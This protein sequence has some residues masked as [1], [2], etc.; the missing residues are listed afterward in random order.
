MFFDCPCG[1]LHVSFFRK[2]FHAGACPFQLV[3]IGGPGAPH[4]FTFLKR[5]DEDL[6]GVEIDESRFSCQRQRGDVILRRTHQSDMHCFEA[7]PH[8][9]MSFTMHLAGQKGGSQAL[10]S[11]RQSRFCL[12]RL[13]LPRCLLECLQACET[14]NT[15]EKTVAVHQGWEF[16]QPLLHRRLVGQA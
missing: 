14:L 11:P 7:P 10:T 1:F 16:F 2:G 12:E 4:M 9:V 8:K 13:L 6:A 15:K 5:S 3:G